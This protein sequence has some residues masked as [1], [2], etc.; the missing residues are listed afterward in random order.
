MDPTSGYRAI[1][2]EVIKIFAHNYPK[3]YPEPDLKG[4]IED[5]PPCRSCIFTDISLMRSFFFFK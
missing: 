5:C 4:V 1:N 2:R 3:D